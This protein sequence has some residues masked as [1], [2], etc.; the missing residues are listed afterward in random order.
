MAGKRRRKETYRGVV[1]VA[2][3]LLVR[4]VDAK[5]ATHDLVVV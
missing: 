5:L 3:L 2:A 4:K 1:V